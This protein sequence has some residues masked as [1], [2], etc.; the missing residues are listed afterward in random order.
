MKVRLMKLHTSRTITWCLPHCKEWTQGDGETSRSS[1]SEPGHLRIG[2]HFDRPGGGGA[3]E[4]LR[5]ILHPGSWVC[6]AIQLPKNLPL[7][8]SAEPAPSHRDSNPLA[9]V[10]GPA[11]PHEVDQKLKLGNRALCVPMLGSGPKG[12]GQPRSLSGVENE[13]ERIRHTHWG[14]DGLPAAFDP[15]V[16]V[17]EA[18]EPPVFLREV[19]PVNLAVAEGSDRVR[20]L[21]VRGCFTLPDVREA[22]RA[23]QPSQV[24]ST[25]RIWEWGAQYPEVRAGYGSAV[26]WPKRRLPLEKRCQASS[27]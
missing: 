23:G 25:E 11:D 16:L 18:Q 7:A 5:G 17:S 14:A 24:T 13:A 19:L 27:P 20:L 9:T 3:Q 1:L 26:Q 21:G 15:T 2:G 22:S 6:I 10:I 12:C 8:T 4:S